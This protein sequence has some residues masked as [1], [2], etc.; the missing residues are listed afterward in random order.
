MTCC[1]SI[2]WRRPSGCA[3]VLCL[4]VLA[5]ACSSN[6]TE[7]A[8]GPAC[9][10]V[11]VLAEASQ[12]VQFTSSESEVS[13]VVFRAEMVNA[14]AS[15]EL[16]DDFVDVALGVQ[17]HAVRGAGKADIYPAR[18]FVAVV[19]AN[20]RILARETFSLPITFEKGQQ[21][22]VLRDSVDEVHIPLESEGAGA[23]YQVIVGFELTPDQV[24]YNRVT[25]G[26]GQA[27]RPAAADGAGDGSTE[28]EQPAAT[29]G[30]D[31][32]SAE[33]DGAAPAEG[34][35]SGSTEA[36]GSSSTD[37]GDAGSTGEEEPAADEGGDS[38][39]TEAEES[40]STDGGDA[41]STEEDE[42]APAEDGESGPAQD[43]Q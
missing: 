17:V 30:A 5:G 2:A 19:D 28:E 6:G 37:G 9:P 10:G 25:S 41:G 42:P 38:G 27:A 21:Q 15:C 7:E 26:Q 18:Y 43:G 16:D 31:S 14:A 24:T 22:A 33:E 8:K 40:A 13:D 23:T 20:E 4:A 39:S 34:D 12:L 11:G 29:E 36:E 1:K 35:E 32:G 3:A